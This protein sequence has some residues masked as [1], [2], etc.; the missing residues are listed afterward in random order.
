[1]ISI[2]IDPVLIHIGPLTVTWH[3]LMVVVGIV[4]AV[5][6]AGRLVRQRSWLSLDTFYSVTIWAVPGGVIGARLVHTGEQ[7]L[8]VI[9]T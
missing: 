9:E 2:N 6:L 1:M 4:A 7:A 8:A 5:V 3:S